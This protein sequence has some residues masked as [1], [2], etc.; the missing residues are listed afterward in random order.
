MSSIRYLKKLIEEI[1]NESA[2]KPRDARSV[3]LALFNNGR[4]FIL[5]DPEIFKEQL[6]NTFTR[7]QFAIKPDK[8]ITDVL[9]RD[10]IYGFISVVKMPKCRNIHKIQFSAARKGYGPL[11]YDIVLSAFGSLMPDRTDVSP[12]ASKIWKYY[13]EKR[14]DVLKSNLPKSCFRHNEKDKP[15]LD[16]KYTATKSI[17]DMKL[18]MNHVNFI[19]WLKT[20]AALH[21]AQD[22][23]DRVI[24]SHLVSVGLKF[25]ELQKKEHAMSDY[26]VD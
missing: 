7:R 14:R 15:E 13:N 2:F 19:Q 11:M 16:L 18:R 25:Y 12:S 10:A 20:E 6:K 3:G 8:F 23:N 9:N 5:Y 26:G 22:V 17:A 4:F 1:V 24:E 21:G